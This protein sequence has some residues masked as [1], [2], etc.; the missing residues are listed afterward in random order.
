M[1]FTATFIAGN[2]CLTAREKAL[3]VDEIRWFCAK[4]L[5]SANFSGSDQIPGFQFFNFADSDQVPS[6]VYINIPG[7]QVG[8]GTAEINIL[9][10]QV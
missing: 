2:T 8:P 7:Y 6:F 9:G 1:S 3:H 5:Q 10:Y 4:I